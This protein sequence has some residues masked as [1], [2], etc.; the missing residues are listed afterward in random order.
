MSDTYPRY[1]SEGVQFA[2]HGGL[3]EFYE[4]YG[5]VDDAKDPSIYDARLDGYLDAA[6]GKV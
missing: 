2:E 5:V 4:K 6:Q 1:Y 3:D